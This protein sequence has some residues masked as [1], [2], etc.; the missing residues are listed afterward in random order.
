VNDNIEIIDDDGDD[1]ALRLDYTRASFGN[2][3]TQPFKR[4][5]GFTSQKNH[6][7]PIDHSRAADEWARRLM[8]D[9]ISED[10]QYL[11]KTAKK[12]LRLKSRDIQKHDEG[13]AGAVETAYFRAEVTSG[14]CPSDPSDVISIYAVTL[15]VP[16]T[17]LPADFD[18]IFPFK[19]SNLS[20]PMIGADR[21]FD[22]LV[23]QLEDRIEGMNIELD[24]NP[25]TGIIRLI[26]S[27]FQE[28]IID[29]KNENMSVQFRDVDGCLA[30]I[31][32]LDGHKFKTIMGHA[33]KGIEG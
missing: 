17:R 15:N 32:H 25:T 29:T 9:K 24:E 14:Q 31:K 8:T 20:I 22:D 26:F 33:P 4:L 23:D 6:K 11:Y 21:A 7:V 19:I 27:V 28:I 12:I 10:L 18:N 5:S 30:L 16:F 1:L 3:D 13:G 2:Q